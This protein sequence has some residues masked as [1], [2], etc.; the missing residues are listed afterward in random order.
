MLLLCM[1]KTSYDIIQL[2]VSGR[3]CRFDHEQEACAEGFMGS[4]S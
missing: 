4:A 2:V 1:N 3:N